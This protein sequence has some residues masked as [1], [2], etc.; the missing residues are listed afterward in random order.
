MSAAG[1]LFDGDDQVVDNLPE[2]FWDLLDGFCD[3]LFE[4]AA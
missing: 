1:P 4:A 2:R 3:Q